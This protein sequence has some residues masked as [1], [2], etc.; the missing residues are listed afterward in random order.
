MYNDLNHVAFQPIARHNFI[1]CCSFSSIEQTALLNA[2]SKGPAT[3]PLLFQS[4]IHVEASVTFQ[5]MDPTSEILQEG[6]FPLV[7]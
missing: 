2:I 4:W 5:K 1:C 7:L 6:L 3:Q